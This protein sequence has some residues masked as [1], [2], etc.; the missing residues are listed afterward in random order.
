MCLHII[1]H[2]LATLALVKLAEFLKWMI[3]TQRKTELKERLCLRAKLH[4]AIEGHEKFN[5]QQQKHQQSNNA[6]A[7]SFK[8]NRYK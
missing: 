4:K 6:C 7:C 8:R 5:K 1:I 3:H 2:A